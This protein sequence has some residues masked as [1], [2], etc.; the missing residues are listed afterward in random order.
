MPVR[1]KCSC[2]KTLSVRDEMAGKTIK[3]PGCS[4][5][6]RVPGGKPKAAPAKPTSDLDDLFA[7]EG[8]DRQVA[9][10]CPACGKEMKAQ[11]VLC[12]SCGFNKNSGER[13]VGHQV[14]GVDVDMGTIQ[15]RQA[16]L[17][18][19][20]D[21]AIQKKMHAKAGMPWYMLFLVLFIIGSGSTLAVLT[22]NAANREEELSFEPMKLFLALV[23]S[24]F[25]ILGAM[26][27]ISVIV[28]AFKSAV[29][30]GFMVML[31]P[32]YILFYVFKSWRVNLKPL[33]LA[34]IAFGIGGYFANSSATYVPPED[35]GTNP[36]IVL[37]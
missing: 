8:F 17:S 12:T 35:N 20:R 30:T 3:C 31:I 33:C 24:I 27:Y 14:D 7:E 9:A 6:I 29:S 13:L 4:K 2:G 11:E 37:D 26:A 16:E 23:A 34:M 15:L 18:M 22:I 36:N 32:L 25:I 5:P 21:V 1:L 10:A 19:Q 28:H